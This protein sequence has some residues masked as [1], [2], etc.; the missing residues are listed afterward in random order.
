MNVASSLAHLFARDLARLAQQI[1]AFPD[2]ITLWQV[3][4]GITNPAGNLILH[5]EGNLR[6]YIGRQLAGVPYLRDRPQEFSLRD[7]CRENLLAKV[8]ELELDI[9]SAIARLTDTQLEGEYP[10]VVFG[11]PLTVQQFLIHLYGH[12][13]WHLGQIDSVRRVQTGQSAIELAKL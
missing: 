5:I 3:P 1:E 12:L 11:R 7:I 9:P 8:K 13:N 10:E 6:E 2:D 4:A